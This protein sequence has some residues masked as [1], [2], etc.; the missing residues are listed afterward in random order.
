[1][2]FRLLLRGIVGVII[3]VVVVVL[4]VAFFHLN[5][6]KAVAKTLIVGKG[7]LPPKGVRT[8][9]LSGSN[10]TESLLLWWLE[11]FSLFSLRLS[12]W[13]G[14]VVRGQQK[15]RWRQG[16]MDH[17]INQW[18][19]FSSLVLVRVSS[20]PCLIGTVS[21]VIPYGVQ[22]SLRYFVHQ[23]RVPT[24]RLQS[25]LINSPWYQ[26]DSPGSPCI[27]QTIDHIRRWWGFGTTLLRTKY[28]ADDHQSRSGQR[29]KAFG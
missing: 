7:A 6:W 18:L 15:W 17:E 14:V 28:L 4:V 23:Y 21:F 25:V 3:A 1:M 12:V 27:I 9:E 20:L 2:F 29:G 16:T 22:N 11:F 8:L 26:A 13:L 5:P 19:G 10:K 24:E